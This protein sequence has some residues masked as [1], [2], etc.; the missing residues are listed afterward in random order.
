MASGEGPLGQAR[1]LS[2]HLSCPSYVFW[3]QLVVHATA[4][5]ASVSTGGSGALEC[6]L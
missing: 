2:W 6:V 3:G 5:R 4:M 1:V